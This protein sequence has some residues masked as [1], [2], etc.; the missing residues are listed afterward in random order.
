MSKNQKE[1]GIMDRK[2]NNI[3]WYDL[4]IKA[5]VY[6][7]ASQAPRIEK[8]KGQFEHMIRSWVMRR[9]GW[10]PEH[11][12]TEDILLKGDILNLADCDAMVTGATLSFPG[13]VDELGEV[14]K[15]TMK[16]PQADE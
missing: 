3:L 7:E 6:F 2:L 4:N 5:T 14:P 13:A 15:L 9:G 11:P 8:L 1:A 12:P 10:W 16:V